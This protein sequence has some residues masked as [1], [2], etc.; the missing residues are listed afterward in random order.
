MDAFQLY[1]ISE[2]FQV[3]ISTS[4]DNAGF[5]MYPLYQAQLPL[6]TYDG[7]SDE[8]IED[9]IMDMES[10]RVVSTYLNN[11]VNRIFYRDGYFYKR[12]GGTYELL[13]GKISMSS[14]GYIEDSY[15]Y[16]KNPGYFEFCFYQG[17]LMKHEK[18]Y[19]FL[20]SLTKFLILLQK[21]FVKT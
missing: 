3:Y 18:Y 16:Y 1:D 4:Y 7:E 15:S 19:T 11:F 10:C 6:R 17:I 12:N 13:H 9:P 8:Y 2:C 21:N 5:S 20:R 14:F